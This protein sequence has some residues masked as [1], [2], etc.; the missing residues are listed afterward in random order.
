[1]RLSILVEPVERPIPNLNINNMPGDTT[2]LSEG[3]T[4]RHRKDDIYYVLQDNSQTPK[5]FLL[6]KEEMLALVEY[7]IDDVMTRT[8]YEKFKSWLNVFGV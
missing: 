6:L 8:E 7:V 5:Q 2:K 4:I 3:T 1:M